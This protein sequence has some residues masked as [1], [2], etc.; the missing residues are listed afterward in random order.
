MRRGRVWERAARSAGWADMPVTGQDPPVPRAARGNPGSVG[1]HVF[2]VGGR[3]DILARLIGAWARRRSRRWDGVA[4]LR[5]GCGWQAGHAGAE[6]PEGLFHDLRVV[7]DGDH[8]HW[9]LA[10]GAAEGIDVPDPQDEISPFFGG[11]FEGR[12]W[13]D[14]RTADD[15]LQRQAAVADAALR[16]VPKPE[17]G[18]QKSIAFCI[19]AN[20]PV[21][22][23]PAG[24]GLGIAE[25]A[26]LSGAN[27]L[28]NMFTLAR[29]DCS[30]LVWN[31]PKACSC[32]GERMV[33]ARS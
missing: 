6:V 1:Q 24:Y 9:V 8:A 18:T 12:W 23:R 26:A 22:W 21:R 11:Q 19:T 16:R 7:N 29:I 15:Q 10:D 33:R 25:P 27:I 13:R 28:R 14:A 20:R 2:V 5:Q 3:I 32:S 4:C 17:P 31:E 30:W